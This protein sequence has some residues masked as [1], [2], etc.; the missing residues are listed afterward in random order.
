LHSE[1]ASGLIDRLDVQSALGHAFDNAPNGIKKGIRA[2][3]L[4]EAGYSS[5]D[6]G[7]VLGL[8]ANS[9]R[10]LASKA[11]GYLRSQP[12]FRALREVELC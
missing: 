11:R 6:A 9:V 3:F 4:M 10:A 7:Q 1:K 5:S 8:P 2:L 12:D